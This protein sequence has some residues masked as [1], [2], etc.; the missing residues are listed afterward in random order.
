MTLVLGQLGDSERRILKRL[1]ENAESARQRWRNHDEEHAEAEAGAM[2]R[3]PAST[4][5]RPRAIARSQG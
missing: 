5:T 1:D 3:R 2:S 4:A